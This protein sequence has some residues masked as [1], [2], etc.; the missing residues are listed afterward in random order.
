MKKRVVK[1]ICYFDKYQQAWK[2]VLF[3][4]HKIL[5]QAP[6]DAS[7][8]L[9]Q[10]ALQRYWGVRCLDSVAV[11]SSPLF[12]YRMTMFASL[13]FSG[14][15]PLSSTGRGFRRARW[16]QRL[17]SI[18]GF[19]LEYHPGR[20]LSQAEVNPGPFPDPAQLVHCPGPPQQVCTLWRFWL[21]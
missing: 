19:L 4:T 14:T 7:E 3:F 6:R 2:R 16:R 1:H 15:S 13:V 17:Y 9:K 8:Q 20:E 18:S 11:A 5:L 12:S 21:P 10:R